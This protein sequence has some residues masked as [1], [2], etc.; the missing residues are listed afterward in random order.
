MKKTLA[1]RL[2]PSE[3][4]AA[5][6]TEM[7]NE[8]F[9]INTYGSAFV[10]VSVLGKDGQRYGSFRRIW[11]KDLEGRYY[12]VERW[13][14]RPSVMLLDTLFDE[15]LPYDVAYVRLTRYNKLKRFRY[16]YKNRKVN[17]GKSRTFQ[18]KA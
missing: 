9:G 10:H 14:Y 2:Y 12:I 13:D 8:Q 5:E 15:R 7:F 1:V 6:L 17:N 16:L 4:A 18:T 11:R 3:K